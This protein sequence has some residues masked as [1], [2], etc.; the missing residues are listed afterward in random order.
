M[1]GTISLEK[2]AVDTVLEQ[3]SLPKRLVLV[4]AALSLVGGLLYY[5]NSWWTTGRFSETTDDAYIGGNVTEISP[6][7]SGFISSI[8]V[9]DNQRVKAG[10]LLVRIA[11]PDFEA[12]EEH[13]AAVV[14]QRRA[15]LA[16]L[17]AKIELQHSLIAQARANLAASRDNANFAARDARRFANLAETHAGSQ[18]EAEKSRTAYQTAQSGVEAAAA[19]VAAA[20]KDLSVLEARVAEA[21]AELSQAQA[22]LKSA[23]LDLGYTEIHAPIDGYVGNRAAQVGAYVQAGSHLLS[24]VPTHGLWVDANFKEDQIHHMHPGQPVSVV[25]DVMPEHPLRGHVVS[26]APAT[27]ATFSVIPPQNATG[28]F[29]KIVQRLPV[30]IAIEDDAYGDILRPGLSATTSVDTRRNMGAAP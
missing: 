27:G 29:T 6:H 14:E 21:K 3:K 16:T 20:Q 26:L 1:S 13:A 7:I 24:I 2:T 4:V 17:R 9:T 30:R 22:A 5:A 19:Q 25:L 28:N 10:Q 15:A 18:R 23:R 12:A 8:A 11:S